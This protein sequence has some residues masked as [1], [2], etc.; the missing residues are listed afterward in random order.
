MD[1]K[2]KTFLKYKNFFKNKIIIFLF[3]F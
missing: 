2:K 1:K 3:C